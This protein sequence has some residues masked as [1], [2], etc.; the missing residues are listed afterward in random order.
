MKR[1]FL[2]GLL[3]TTSLAL[4]AQRYGVT[5]TYNPQYETSGVKEYA[6]SVGIFVARPKVSKDAH[7][8]HST[9]AWH[10]TNMEWIK[11][12]C[13]VKNVSIEKDYLRIFP[14]VVNMPLDDQ[15]MKQCSTATSACLPTR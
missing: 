2:I 8:R 6:K 11:D 12:Y 13:E 7:A 1:W 9:A 10:M 4:Q 3:A 15:P 5:L 14:E